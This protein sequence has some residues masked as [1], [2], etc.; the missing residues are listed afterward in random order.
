MSDRDI[1]ANKQWH[2]FAVTN[3]S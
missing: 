1:Y 3:Q 2:H